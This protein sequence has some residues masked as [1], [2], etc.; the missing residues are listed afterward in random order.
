M[1]LSENKLNWLYGIH[2]GSSWGGAIL[3]L[4]AILYRQLFDTLAP[5]WVGF[6]LLGQCSAFIR[7]RSTRY[8]VWGLCH[9][10]GIVIWT[11]I[12]I[13]VLLYRR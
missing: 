5:Y 4:I 12:L 7:A 6:I 8:K 3:L 2:I 9:L 1:K 13:V 11:A 10:G